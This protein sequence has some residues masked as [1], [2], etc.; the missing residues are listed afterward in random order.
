MNKISKYLTIIFVVV[1]LAV[2]FLAKPF[3]SEL[4]DEQLGRQMGD[5]IYEQLT[6]IE[7]E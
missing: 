1:L 6:N 5:A 3:A 7:E 4:T 2:L